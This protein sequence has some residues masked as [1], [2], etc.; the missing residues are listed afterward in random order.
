MA[1]PNRQMQ[2][3]LDAH[4]AMGTLAVESLTAQLARQT[5]TIDRAVAAVYGKHLVMRALGPMQTPV[6]RIEHHRFPGLGGELVARLYVPEEEKPDGGW[7]VLVYYHGGGWV[8]G[9]LDAYDASCR[10]LCEQAQCVVVAAHY[11]QAPE[12]PWPAAV[13]DAFT[14]YQWAIANAASFGGN[15]DI[16]AVAGEG[17]GGNLAAVVCLAAR[18]RGIQR[19]LHQLLIYPVTDLAG[20]FDNMSAHDH[21]S[22]RPLSRPMLLWFYN[23]YAPRGINR[24]HAYLSPLH[25]PSLADLPPATIINAEIDP[26][27]D[28]GEAYADRLEQARVRVQW[29]LYP[30]V[31]HEFFGMTGVLDEADA[32]AA[33]AADTLR[34]A[35]EKARRAES[36]EAGGT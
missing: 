4:A 1:R 12:H 5:P 25:A 13:E 9:T 31:T 10:A 18:D 27:R 17:S 24:G 15:G 6:G 32:A 28:D 2:E 29:K 16:A 11:R 26:L 33:L 34:Y 35:F 20:G 7:P 36:V 23:Q 22:A 21:A 30:G 14:A 8:L 3:I 19:P